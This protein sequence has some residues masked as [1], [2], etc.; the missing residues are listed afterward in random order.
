MTPILTANPRPNIWREICKT[1]PLKCLV[2]DET[3]WMS[4]CFIAFNKNV[5]IYFQPFRPETSSTILFS[6][7]MSGRANTV[8]TTTNE[9]VCCSS[10]QQSPEKRMATLRRLVHVCRWQ[11]KIERE[12][13]TETGWESRMTKE[14]RIE[15][16]CF[17]NQRPKRILF[18]L[19][20]SSIFFRSFRKNQKTTT[21]FL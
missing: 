17:V 2:G 12:R 15:E 19:R 5:I 14:A 20:W 8:L 4:R 1:F 6:V 11:S 7:L 10:S 21:K 13:E 18:I 16:R 9:V 3:I